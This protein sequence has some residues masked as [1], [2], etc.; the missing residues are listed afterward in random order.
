M[1]ICGKGCSFGAVQHSFEIGFNQFIGISY[2]I[3]SCCTIWN[4]IRAFST[5][6]DDIMHSGCIVQMLSQ[7]L[8]ACVHDLNGIQS[9]SSNPWGSTGVGRFPMEGDGEGPIGIATYSI[10]CT[11]TVSTM[12]I[13]DNIDIIEQPGM[14]H[15]RTTD[16]GFFR[17][18]TK[19]FNGSGKSALFHGFFDGDY[20]P[21]SSST[22]GVMGASMP[23]CYGT[24]DF[25]YGSMVR[26]CYFLR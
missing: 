11:K 22:H 4:N 3:P 18:A 20:R 1:S 9:G 13:D 8:G 6:R 16:D 25:R 10:R 14:N 15:E 7:I 5:F 2:I 23:R 19:H 12:V 21:G 26:I 17:R 24:L